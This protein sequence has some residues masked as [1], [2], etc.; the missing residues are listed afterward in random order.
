MGPGV[1]RFEVLSHAV[2]TM[3]GSGAVTHQS[4]QWLEWV[5]ILGQILIIRDGAAELAGMVLPMSD[6]SGMGWHRRSWHALVRVMRRSR[7]PLWS[8][9]R[10]WNSS[11]IVT[12]RSADVHVWATAVSPYHGMGRA[13]LDTPVTRTAGPRQGTVPWYLQRTKP[14]K[15]VE[16]ANES[17]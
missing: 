3:M 7:E 14:L 13:L 12:C 1:A 8:T 16:I 5:T 11:A 10:Q 9:C 17:R 6:I 15:P 2:L 4:R